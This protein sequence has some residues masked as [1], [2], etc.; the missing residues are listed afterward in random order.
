[1][2]KA[3]I[4]Y[5]VQ[6][7]THGTESKLWAGKMVAVPKPTNKRDRMGGCPVCA[8]EARKEQPTT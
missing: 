3:K 4:R 5:V 6:C 7:K 1:M 2:S 8:A